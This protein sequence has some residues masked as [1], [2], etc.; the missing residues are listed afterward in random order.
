MDGRTHYF[1]AEQFFYDKESNTMSQEL[2]SLRLMRFP[3]IIRSWSNATGRQVEFTLAHVDRHNFQA[4]Y[5]PQSLDGNPTNVKR[6]VLF[7]D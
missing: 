3:S 4:I 7:N 5:L 1:N 2:S 6:L